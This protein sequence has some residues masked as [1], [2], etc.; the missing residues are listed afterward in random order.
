[1]VRRHKDEFE[2]HQT[3]RYFF[4]NIFPCTENKPIYKDAQILERMNDLD[5]I[6][7]FRVAR[8]NDTGYVRANRGWRVQT[9]NTIGDMSKNAYI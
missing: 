3:L 1:M 7:S 8:E 4:T 5:R 2:F 9:N 6:I